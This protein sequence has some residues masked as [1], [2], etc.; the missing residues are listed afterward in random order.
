MEFTTF[1]VMFPCISLETVKISLLIST[2]KNTASV[3]AVAMKD[4]KTGRKTLTTVA[5]FDNNTPV[6]GLNV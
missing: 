4:N 6:E 2:T 5:K 1:F 3:F